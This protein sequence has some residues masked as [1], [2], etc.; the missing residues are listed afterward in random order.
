MASTDPPIALRIALLKSQI[1]ELG[2]QIDSYKAKTA[3]ALGGAVFTLL[4]AAGGVYDL[5]NGKT[6]LWSGIGISKE[7]FKWLVPG[8]AACS[9]ALFALAWVRESKRDRG[10]NSTLEDLEEELAEL[11][12]RGTC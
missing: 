6:S 9:L 1:Q 10:L 4:L 8:L 2:E 5:L 7:L 11:R 12:E 3:G